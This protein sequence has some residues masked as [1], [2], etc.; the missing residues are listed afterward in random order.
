MEFVTGNERN[1]WPEWW[2]P[3]CHTASGCVEMRSVFDPSQWIDGKNYV[4]DPSNYHVISVE[5]FIKFI[6]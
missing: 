4:I 1:A 5:D 3:G 2:A 6:I